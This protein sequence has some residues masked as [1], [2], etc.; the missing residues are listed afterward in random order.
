MTPIDP[1]PFGHDQDQAA[2]L[3]ERVCEAHE[4]GAPLRILGGDSKSF[5]GL[6][7]SGTPL[8]VTGH[9]GIVHYDP[10]ELILTAR[11]GTP[12]A[13]IEAA[14]ADSGQFLPF[15]PPH[16]ATTATLGGCIA[17]G[18]SGPRRPWSGAVRDFVLG[19]RCIGHDGVIRRF[20]GEVMKNVAGYD[21]SRL[22]VGAFGTLG[23]LTEVSLKVLPRPRASATIRLELALPEALRQL[24]DWGREPLPISGAAWLEGRLHLRLEGGTGSVQGAL[25]R[26]GGEEIDAEFWTLL[27]E[28]RH[29]F[30]SAEDPRPL[31]R[32]SVPMQTPPLVLDGDWLVDW[33]GAQRWLRSSASAVEIRA[34]AENAGGHASC[35]TP[36]VAEPFHPLQP[37]VLH[38]HRQLKQQFDPRGIF[39]PGRMYGDL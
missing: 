24:A 4:R 19:V 12:L 35:F 1:E 29:P 10:V 5:L 36:G 25:V 3:A 33:A 30:F 2:A 39:N 17:A 16:F 23:V 31:W 20:G 34:A 15:E 28:Q 8:D 9:C 37:I 32:L 6:S 13:R 38:Y 11:T 22:M 27:R 21:V 26:L 7:V 14:L 18:L